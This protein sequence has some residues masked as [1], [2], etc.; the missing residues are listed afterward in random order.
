MKFKLACVIAL[1]FLVSC[2]TADFDHDNPIEEENL[3]DALA[4]EDMS[5]E[6]SEEEEEELMMNQM[7]IRISRNSPILSQI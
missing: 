7:P 1:L 5:P 4:D 2:I 6:R 3:K